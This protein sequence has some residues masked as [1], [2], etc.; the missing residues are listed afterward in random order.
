MRSLLSRLKDIK[1]GDVCS[2]ATPYGHTMRLVLRVGNIHPRDS[3]E[4]GFK[5]PKKPQPGPEEFLPN[6][7]LHSGYR[8]TVYTPNESMFDTVRKRESVPHSLELV[9]LYAYSADF[10]IPAK[11]WNSLLREHKGT[12]PEH[13][14]RDPSHYVMI[15]PH[16][17]IFYMDIARHRAVQC[18]LPIPVSA[19]SE[20]ERQHR[21]TILDHYGIQHPEQ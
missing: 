6:I 12:V 18:F 21:R 3:A 13:V 8:P 11:K 4:I 20:P 19:L 17:H 15:R 10:T 2:W 1:P 16:G 9:E 5:D 7:R 14:L